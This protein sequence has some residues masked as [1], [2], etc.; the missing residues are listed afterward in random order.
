MLSVT[1]MAA[2]MS[3]EIRVNAKNFNRVE[4]LV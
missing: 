1:P 3:K 4:G 2:Q